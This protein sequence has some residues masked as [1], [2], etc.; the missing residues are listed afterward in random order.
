MYPLRDPETM[1]S[2]NRPGRDRLLAGYLGW[3]NTSLRNANLTSLSISEVKEKKLEHLTR[4]GDML[5]S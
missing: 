3:V 1:K 2:S 5:S 4:K